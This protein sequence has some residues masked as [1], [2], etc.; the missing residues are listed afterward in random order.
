MRPRRGR[1]RFVWD[2]VGI[3]L[4]LVIASRSTG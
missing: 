1:T 4:F 2:A 3:A